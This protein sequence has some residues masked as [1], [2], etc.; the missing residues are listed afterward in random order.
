MS[1]KHF[2]KSGIAEA[3]SEEREVRAAAGG[4][5]AA[6]VCDGGA[7]CSTFDRSNSLRLHSC[8]RVTCF[9]LHGRGGGKRGRERGK[10]GGG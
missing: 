9:D 6:A 7:S 5:R 2:Y 4:A 1:T 10:R 3:I 8:S